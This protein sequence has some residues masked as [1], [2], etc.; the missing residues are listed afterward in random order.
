[1]EVEA[2]GW[3]YP[4]DG[5]NQWDAIT[6]VGGV[7]QSDAM[8]PVGRA[9]ER[10]GL[11]HEIGGDNGIPQHSYMEGQYKLIKYHPVIYDW[12]HWVCTEL[13]CPMGWNPLPGQ[14]RPSGPPAAENRTNGTAALLTGGASS[15]GIHPFH[16]LV[17]G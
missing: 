7:N 14:G 16:L 11:V 9:Q 10:V 15:S 1:L 2:D 8:Q 13:E 17:L 5:V 6:T 4:I 12:D 3:P